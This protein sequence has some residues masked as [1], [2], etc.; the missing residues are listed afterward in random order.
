LDHL[1]RLGPVR[2]ASLNAVALETGESP[3]SKRAHVAPHDTPAIQRTAQEEHRPKKYCR[4]KSCP[5]GDT[6]PN[7]LCAS[8]F[9]A[10][11][12]FGLGVHQ[13][14]TLLWHLNTRSQ[15]GTKSYRYIKPLTDC[16]FDWAAWPLRSHRFRRTP[17]A[18][19][20]RSPA[21]S[22]SIPL[23]VPG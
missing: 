23:I 9:V 8:L 20:R 15:I 21:I 17:R 7:P 18:S 13:R 1:P 2:A 11:P 12:L 3:C 10:R 14:S 22:C 16:G 19:Q 4:R 5:K 6:N